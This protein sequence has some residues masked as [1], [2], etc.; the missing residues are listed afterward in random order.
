MMARKGPQAWGSVTVKVPASLSKAKRDL[1]SSQTATS[2]SGV[3]L[4]MS[5]SRSP[6]YSPSAMG[7]V[8]SPEGQPMIDSIIIHWPLLGPDWS[9]ARS[10]E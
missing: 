5:P 10:Q 4:A 8:M 1:T 9:R 6:A 2:S 3:A 7:S